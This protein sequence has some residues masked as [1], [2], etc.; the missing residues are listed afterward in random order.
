MITVT[1]QMSEIVQEGKKSAKTPEGQQILAQAA[2]DP[3]MRWQFQLSTKRPLHS[4]SAHR[5]GSQTR[6]THFP[7][8]ETTQHVALALRAH[9]QVNQQRVRQFC[10]QRPL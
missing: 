6:E 7:S 4:C 10:L 2:S 3:V 5:E 8:K 9:R 1:V